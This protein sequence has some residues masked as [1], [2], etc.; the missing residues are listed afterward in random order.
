[1]TNEQT[2]SKSTISPHSCF[3]AEDQS[4]LVRGAHR[5][6]IGSI[7]DSSDGFRVFRYGRAL[8]KFKTM[9]AAVKALERADRLEPIR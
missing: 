9:L 7:T 4:Y 1:M 6:S 8:G 2:I 5:D 3:P